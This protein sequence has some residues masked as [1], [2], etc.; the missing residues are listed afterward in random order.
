MLRK[1][2]SSLP[3]LHF[4]MPKTCIADD[5]PATEVDSDIFTESQT[6][7]F[8]HDVSAFKAHLRK[9]K[10]V[11]GANTEFWEGVERQQDVYIFSFYQ[12]VASQIPNLMVV[13][14]KILSNISA[15]ATCERT[16]HV[17]GNVLSIRRCRLTPVRAQK[18]IPSAFRFRCNIRASKV[19]FHPSFGVI[20]IRDN[21]D[22]DI[23]KE[24]EQ[25]RFDDDAA[26]WEAFFEE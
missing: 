10:K 26:A 11:A 2:K 19:P 17:A 22:Y 13:I 21:P 16:F 7:D 3:L 5:S 1:T 4:R 24:V 9:V 12:A 25:E 23:D 18:F 8:S 6:I 14:R 20:D 15:I